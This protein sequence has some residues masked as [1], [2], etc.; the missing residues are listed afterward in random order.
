MQTILEKVDKME[1]R[2]IETL[3]AEGA[4][5]AITRALDYD[6]KDNIYTFICQQYEIEE[7]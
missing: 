7:E 1:E 6:T 2:I 4:L 3:G 5:N